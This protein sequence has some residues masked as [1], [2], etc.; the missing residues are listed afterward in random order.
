MASTDH[1]LEITINGDNQTSDIIKVQN[2]VRYHIVASSE[3]QFSGKIH[4]EAKYTDSQDW[5]SLGSFKESF[6]DHDFFPAPTFIRVTCRSG[7]YNQG[8]ITIYI[9]GERVE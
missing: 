7:D 8:S 3:P 1:Y 9:D 6:L 2:Y 4:F 5:I